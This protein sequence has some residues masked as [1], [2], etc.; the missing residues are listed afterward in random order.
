[1]SI[2]RAIALAASV[3]A[4]PAVA[5]AA[6]PPATTVAATVTPDSTTHYRVD[7]KKAHS[8]VLTLG[9][10]WKVT[11]TVSTRHPKRGSRVRFSGTVGPVH[12]GGTVEIQRL[13]ASGFKTVKTA[14][15]TAA[16][17]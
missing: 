13:T 8:A 7:V 3:C 9:V 1:M 5:L 15:L 14:T 2:T 12:T 10:R 11:R 16:T 17:A 4:I 6:K